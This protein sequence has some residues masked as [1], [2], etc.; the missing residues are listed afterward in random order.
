M[1]TEVIPSQLSSGTFPLLVTLLQETMLG[2]SFRWPLC[3]W[4]TNPHWLAWGCPLFLSE[5]HLETSVA[6]GLPC[7]IG[8]MKS[9]KRLEIPVHVV[10]TA[11]VWVITLGSRSR[12][13]RCI[14]I[15]PSYTIFLPSQATQPQRTC[16]SH[17]TFSWLP[18]CPQSS[19]PPSGVSNIKQEPT[20][21]PRIALLLKLPRNEEK[22]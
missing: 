12:D 1:E 4:A 16:P 7:H 2:H 18:L 21:S 22:Y 11:R 8:D 17:P 5:A 19:S 3:L 14:T 9:L 20:F 10:L 6:W 15:A 13:P